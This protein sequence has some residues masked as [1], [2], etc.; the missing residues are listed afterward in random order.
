M[1]QRQVALLLGRNPSKFRAKK[2]A[3]G[4]HMIVNGLKAN[5]D[6]PAENLTWFDA[7]EAA[8]AA[9]KAKGFKPAYVIENI[10][11]GNDGSIESADIRPN[12][13]SIYETEGYEDGTNGY[14]LPTEAEW[15]YA[16]R[17]GTKTPHWFDAGNIV[18]HAWSY[19]N[20]GGRTHAVGDNDH[21]NALGLYDMLG[22]VYE[23]VQDW[24]GEY[25]KPGMQSDKVA[26]DPTG[27]ATGSYRVF[28]GGSWDRDAWHLRAALRSFVGPGR[29]F[30]YVGARLVRSRR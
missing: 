6:H 8:N 26:T 2:S 3:D 16:A 21:A 30:P 22:N 19:V 24:Y 12:G 23:W 11:Q 4:D 9:S 14:R 13:P 28:R 27:V 7:V 17:A 25:P 5:G 1:T 10:R 20:S 29:R 18:R 15:E